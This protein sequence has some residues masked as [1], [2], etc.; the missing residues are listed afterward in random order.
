MARPQVHGYDL[1]CLTMMPNHRFASGAEEKLVR[2]F[3]ATKNFIDNMSA[4]DQS[5][6]YNDGDFLAQGASVPSLGLS[7]KAVLEGDTEPIPEMERHVKDQFP[8]FYFKPELHDKPP[9]EET[10]VQNTLWP[11][12]QKLY[13]HGYEI[14][15][16]ASNHQ[17]TILATACK[18]AQ[19]EHANIL[20]W[21]TQNWTKLSSLENGHTLTV[22]QMTFS[23]DDKYLLTVSRDRTLSVWNMSDFSLHFKTDKKSSVHQ[24]IIWACDWSK[25]S[26]LFVTVGRDKKCV[27]WSVLEKVPFCLEALILPNAAT[28][29][30]ILPN[31]QVQALTVVIGLDDGQIYFAQLDKST[32]TWSELSKIEQGHHKTVKKLK[33]RPAAAGATRD[34]TLATCGS[35]HLVQLLNFSSLKEE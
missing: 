8:D 15:A 28:A 19:A 23:P 1:N 9:P 11:E 32:K 13:G 5:H 35:D 18:A 21:S 7:N 20:L 33:F 6:C 27:V 34:L 26:S 12:L 25:D 17:G 31:D 22:V 3:E 4:I 10:L 24:R 29:V 16:V 2:V 14:F 30:A